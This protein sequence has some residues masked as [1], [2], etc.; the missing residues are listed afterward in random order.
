MQ[1]HIWKM[2]NS[3]VETVTSTGDKLLLALAVV[4]VIAG[5]VGF[6]A[7]TAE[8]VYARGGAL[9]AG[10]VLG[11]GAGLFS[12]AGKRFIAFAKDAYREVSKVVWPTR[13]EATQTTAIVFAFVVAMALYLWLSDKTIE[14][15]VFSLILGW[16]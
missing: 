10:L 5:V 12:Q 4:L 9:I 13:K 14:W 1:V 8:G 6:Y 11:A 15:V 2:A 7:L 16:K 3:S